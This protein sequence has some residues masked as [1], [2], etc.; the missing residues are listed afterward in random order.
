MLIDTHKSGNARVWGIPQEDVNWEKGFWKERFDLCA[1]ATIP[2][3]FRMF[4]DND[5]I[6]HVVEN[7]RIAAGIHQGEHQ[8]TPYGDGD[9]YKLLEGAF[10]VA[11]KRG[12]HRLEERLESYVELIAAAQQED[13]YISTKQIIGERLGGSKRMGDINDFEL[14][15]FGHLFT[16]A[17]AHKRITGRDTFLNVARRAAGYLKG[18]YEEAARTKEVKTA[19]C[20]SHYM[21]L[22]ELYRTTGE[23]QYLEMAQLALDLRDLVKNGTDDNQ[24]RLPLRQHRKIA[25]HGVRSTYLYAGAADLYAETGEPELKEMLDAVWDN[26]V[27]QKLYITGGCGALYTGVSPYGTFWGVDRVHQAFGYEYQLPNITAYN[28]T[29]ASLGNI[30]WNLRMFASEPDAKYFDVIERTLLNVTLASVSLTGDRYFYE[31]MLRR[32]KSLDYELA[33]PRERSEMLTC[34]C[35]PPNMARTIAQ[36]SE[37]A[38]MVS[39]DAVYTGIY[40]ASRARFHLDNGAEFTLVQQTDYP[41]D[42]EIVISFEEAN[43][44]PFSLMLRIP[45][46]SREGYLEIGGNRQKLDRSHAGTYLQVPIQDAGNVRICLGLD[47]RPRL[48]MAHTKV[49]EDANQAAVERGPLVYCMEGCDTGQACLDDLM[50][51]ACAVFEAAPYQIQTAAEPNAAEISSD[52]PSDTSSDTSAA[53]TVIALE[54]EAVVLHRKGWNRDCLYQ[55]VEFA[56]TH[57]EKIRMIPYFAWDNRGFGE[58]RIWMPIYWGK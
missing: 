26:C 16:A 5:R 11:A 37:Y 45:A 2:H 19:V 58:M 56:G 54:T 53:P 27:N 47:M 9:L 23:E 43:S 3:I 20:P 30:F 52:T 50:L 36:S 31:N 12:D 17:C 6:F 42:G 34:Y 51:P 55:P 35:C 1:D 57:R 38:Y 15:N 8:G 13:G 29:C 46:W 7:F 24:D 21:G 10:Y 4:E 33:W 44:T 41:W 14:Y 18:M 40:G 32:T 48:T 22:V 39:E 49:E 28:E 25:G